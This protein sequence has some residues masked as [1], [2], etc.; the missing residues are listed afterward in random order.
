M[1]LLMDSTTGTERHRGNASG[2]WA[3]LT[4][5][6]GAAVVVGYVSTILVVVQGA[7]AVGATLA[8]QAS[9][10]AITCFAMA[11]CS[12]WLGVRHHMPLIV[13]WSTPGSA[14]LASSASALQGV[15]YP[16]A[17]GAFVFAGVLMVM[18][19]LIK[20]LASLIERMPPGIAA[21]MLA[22]V[23][24]K[25]VLAIPGAA[26][27]DPLAVVPLIIIYLL[28]RL[29][30]SLF[31]VP[32]VVFAG[33]IMALFEGGQ[34]NAIPIGITPLIF[35][36]PEFHWQPLVSIG[37]PLYLVT[38]ASQNLP[39]FAVHRS[40]GY[41]PPV[42]S[43]LATTGIGSAISALFGAHA[44]NMA[45]ITASLVAGPDTHPDPDQRWKVV[46]PYLIIYG[47]F[48]MAAATF[49]ATLGALPAPIVAAIA[50]LALFG[51]MAGSISTMVKTSSEIEPALI[52]FVVTA[53]GMTL[54]GIGA[55]FWGLVAGLIYWF[56]SVR[57]FAGE[58]KS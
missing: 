31:A 51:P 5:S 18:T 21:A 2:S 36:M 42:Q 49:I 15:T 39:G 8:E 29:M 50:G 53:S 33:V 32:I 27:L 58:G 19:A 11:V 44:V 10:A 23:L 46:F 22:G 20:P 30:G 16:E 6:A 41:S 12:L 34:L 3:T 55:A 56:V 57:I 17:I 7:A 54:L 45:A 14:L 37:V 25:F 9:C 28:L 1:G 47:A 24:F 26:L 43:C 48:G 40:Y 35:T 13:A 38:M 52:T 4:A